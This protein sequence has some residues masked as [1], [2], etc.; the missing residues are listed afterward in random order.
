MELYDKEIER[1]VIGSLLTS[2]EAYD[3]SAD[4]LTKECFYVTEHAH[5]YE[6]VSDLAGKGEATDWFSVARL[7]TEKGWQK[8]PNELVLEYGREIIPLST[9]RQH[10]AVLHD[11]WVK[12]RLLLIAE[13]LKAKV[14]DFQADAYEITNQLTQK[15]SSL[16][17][18]MQ[19]GI[20]TTVETIIELQEVMRKNY[21]GDR[22]VTGTPTGF[23]RID[24]SVGGLHPTD[25]VIVAAESSQGKSSIALNIS[26]NAARRGEPIAIYSMEMSRIQLVARMV[27]AESGIPASAILYKRLSEDQMI[28]ADEAMGGLG[29]CKIY[30]DDNSSSSIDSIV[31]SIR[32]MVRRY[33]IRGAVIDYIQLLSLNSKRIESVEQ[34]LGEYARTM[35]NLAKELDIWIMAISQ[36]NRD[37]QNPVPN[38]NRLRGSGQLKEAADT[39][40]MIYRPEACNPPVSSY[41][42]PWNNVDTHGTALVKITKGRNIGLMEFIVGFDAER[43]M[44]YDL[45]DA[46]TTP[47][48]VDEVPEQIRRQVNEQERLPF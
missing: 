33:H 13:E 37:R 18:N 6:C 38:D 35:K 34:A 47:P 46:P 28:R 26:V 36:L 19:T 16:Y 7:M 45:D 30:F 41:P 1:A 10:V 17:R 4:L 12:R 40:M 5:L 23:R 14:Y 20:V 11:L 15:A 29:G 32:F 42:S 9:L 3:E 2:R 44:F 22:P 39:V 25:L 27:A 24:E 8:K 43:T 31:S 48:P 21:S